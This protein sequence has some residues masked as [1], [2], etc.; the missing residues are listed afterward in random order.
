MKTERITSGTW[1]RQLLVNAMPALG[2]PSGGEPCVAKTLMIYR[3]WR[4][5]SR[6]RVAAWEAAAADPW[7]CSVAGVD[8]LRPALVRAATAELARL[9]RSPC[10]I[11][12]RSLIM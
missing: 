12:T 10:G 3:I 4:R 9:S 8:A 5:C 1:P 2:K 6:D 11:I 7:D